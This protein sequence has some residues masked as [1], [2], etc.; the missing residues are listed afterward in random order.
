MVEIDL[1]TVSTLL[2][3]AGVIAGLIVAIFKICQRFNR[4]EDTQKALQDELIRSGKTHRVLMEGLYA[5]LDGLHQQGC[6]GNVTKALN[7][8]HEH[9]FGEIE[10]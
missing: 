1:K 10:Q 9:L 2:S 6:N 7:M 3:I 8:L 4:M 5:C